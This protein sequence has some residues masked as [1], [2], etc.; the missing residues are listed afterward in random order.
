MTS[1]VSDAAVAAHDPASVATGLGA[2]DYLADEGLAT[3]VFLMLRLQRPLFLEGDAG[4]GKTEVAKALAAW[5]GGRLVRLQCYE[6]IDAGQA[7][8]EWDHARQ[9]LHLRAAEAAGRA[10]QAGTEA[11]EDE[12]YDERFLVRRPLLAALHTPEGSPPPVLLI[13]EID[14]ADDEFEA[15]LLEVLSTW[16]VTIPELGTVS[17]QTPPFVVL[18]SNRTRELHDALKRRCLYHW[19]EHPG[20]ERELQIV[21]TRLPEV[22]QTLAHEL[23][24]N[25]GSTHDRETESINGYL[26]FG[27]YQYS[28]GYR[29]DGPPAFATVMAYSSGQ[30]W[31]GYFSSP[32]S[33][34]CGARCGVAQR[35]DNVRSLNATAPQVAA[36]RAPHGTLSIVDTA[37]HEPDPG[38]TDLMVFPIRLSGPAPAGGVHFDTVVTGG[39]A[40]PGDDYVAP[41]QTAG[42]IPEGERSTSMTIEII[43]DSTREP[44]ETVLVELINVVGAPVHQ[45]QAAGTIINDDP[46]P[47]LS[48]RIRFH[49]APAPDSAFPLVVRGIEDGFSTREIE[50][51]PPAF[52]Y[53]VPVIKGASVEMEVHAP[54][55]FAILPF[56]VEEVEAPTVRDITLRKGLQVSGKVTWAAGEPA[57]TVPIQLDILA[58]IDT[59]YQP[60]APVSL[61]PPDFRYTYWVVPQAWLYMAATPPEPYQPFFVTHSYLDSDLVQDIQLSQLPGLVLWGGGRTRVAPDVNGTMNFIVQ[62]SAPA[63]EGGVRMRYRS[64]DGTARAGTHYTAIEGTIEIP[65]G[66]IASHTDMVEWFGSTITGERYFDVVL[67]DIVGANP[68]VSR[69]RIVL[70][71]QDREMSEPLRPRRKR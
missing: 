71:E 60:L 56:I 22:E 69:L 37:I 64:V 24:H 9:L 10:S 20:L 68:I 52:S 38:H 30:P 49:G 46:R 70:A 34:G 14:R 21:H 41:T 61:E 32:S 23:G 26:Q 8:F 63:P 33:M 53:S 39:T 40:R 35:A 59:H 45:A 1:T 19:I 67:T 5:T 62:L 55:P 65:A 66:E 29:Q 48:G 3:A 44:D 47:T 18:T 6:G 36:F 57:P 11:L 42:W 28:F 16:S 4:V 2:H 27:A 54:P 51:S 58:S 12:L 43:G 15:F 17:A 13:D 50:L 7:L 25:M 31:I